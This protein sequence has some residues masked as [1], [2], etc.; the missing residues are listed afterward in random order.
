MNQ[1]IVTVRRSRDANSAKNALTNF[2]DEVAKDPNISVKD[3]SNPTLLV[4]EAPDDA[5]V[6]L[7]SQF[8][9]ELI[10]EPNR[11]LKMF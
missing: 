1:F 7:K 5:I 8:R 9:S 10:I 11:S 6:K 4:I 3:R 2:L